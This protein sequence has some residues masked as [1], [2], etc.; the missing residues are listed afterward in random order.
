MPILN[1]GRVRFN[2]RG[3]YDAAASYAEY[4]V[5]EDDGQS[6]FCT[7]P[8]SGT[9][10]NDTGGSGYWDDMLV[11]GADYNAARAQALQAASEADSSAQSAAGNAQQ[12]GQDRTATGE[13]RQAADTSAQLAGKWAS[14]AEDV[15]VEPGKF[16]AYHWSQKAKS[17]ADLGWDAVQDKPVTATRWPAFSEVTDTPEAATRWP[18]FDEVTDKPTTFPPATHSHTWT[19]V[20]DKPTTFPPATHSH[21]ISAVTGLQSALDGKRSNTDAIQVIS[22]STTAAA[23]QTYVLTSSLALILPAS[24]RVGDWVRVSN[25]SGGETCVVGRNGANIMGL[26]EDLTIDAANAAITLSYA[27]ATRG[28]VLA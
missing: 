6:Y 16:S 15:E 13:D 12:T 23:F 20:T 24:P 21:A 3:Q 7:A 19:S 5:V 22:D 26:A 25:L 8:I 2:W 28:W 14:E 9:G 10:P 27:D 11:R 18:T 4:D 1:L 17:A